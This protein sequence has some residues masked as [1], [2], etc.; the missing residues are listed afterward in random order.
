MK[1]HKEVMEALLEGKTLTWKLEFEGIRPEIRMES[2]GNV[3]GNTFYTIG[4]AIKTPQY[5][6]IKECKYKLRSLD[7]LLDDP[8]IRY[9]HRLLIHKERVVPLPLNALVHLRGM[10]I[11]HLNKNFTVDGVEY[12]IERWMVDEI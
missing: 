2:C 9:E 5:W 6:E 12:I 8:N 7:S 1:N 4:N 11:T 3:K 10:E